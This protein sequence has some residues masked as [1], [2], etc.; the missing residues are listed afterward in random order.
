MSE[1]MTRFSL[2]LLAAF[3]CASCFPT[4]VQAQEYDEV[5]YDDLINQ[6]NKKHAQNSQI[7]NNNSIL[8]DITL[9]AGFGL[10]TSNMTV[11]EP[12]RTEQLQLTGFQMSFGIDLFSPNFV[13]EGALRNFGSAND[14]SES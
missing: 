10:I 13:A 2:F 9:H 14:G 11:Q 12:N 5:S 3:F 4:K 6:I 1:L 8:D 7:Q